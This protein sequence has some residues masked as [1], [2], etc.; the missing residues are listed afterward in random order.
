[1]DMKGQEVQ[2]LLKERYRMIREPPMRS[3]LQVQDKV[4]SVLRDF[5]KNNGFLEI[6]APIIGPVTDPARA[7]FNFIPQSQIQ[8][9]FPS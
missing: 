7:R 9:L 4:L 6:L 5:L 1:M 2:E 3:V 8:T